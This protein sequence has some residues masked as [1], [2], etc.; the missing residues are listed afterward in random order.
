[1]SV[2]LFMNRYLLVFGGIHE[3]TYE[4][5]DFRMFDMQTHK[6]HVLDEENKNASES[7]SPAHRQ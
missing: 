5:N 3:V 2:C 6:W 4:M 7:G 1:M